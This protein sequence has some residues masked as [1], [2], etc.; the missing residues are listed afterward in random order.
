MMAVAPDARATG[1][2]DEGAPPT[3]PYY[4]DRLP[5]KPPSEVFFEAAGSPAA[6]SV[7]FKA[8]ALALAAA[9]EKAG[10]KP[11]AL[12]ADAEAL[13][14]QARLDTTR[15][16]KLCNF[17]NDVRDLFAAAPPV[18]GKP[19]ANYIRWRVEHADWFDLEWAPKKEAPN[20]GNSER[21]VKGSY[22]VLQAKAND[23]S[24]GALR[25]HWLYLMGAY[26]Y[27]EGSE[28][29]FQ[30][31]VNEFP[32][33]PRAEAARFMLARCRLVASRSHGRNG[34]EP[35]A[36]STAAGAKDRARAQELFKDYLKRYPTGRFAA[37]APGWLGA[38]AFDEG[39]YLGALGWYLQQADTPGHPEVLK[40]AGFMCERCL[41]RLSA[42]GDQ[43][44]LRQVAEHPKLAM[45]LIYLLVNT[46]ETDNNNGA[47]ETPEEVGRWRRALLPR[48]AAEVAAHESAYKSADWQPRYLAILAQAASGEG[49]QTKALALC[50]MAKDQIDRNDDLAFIRLTALQRARRLPEAVAAGRAFQEHFPHSPLARGAAL[51]MA[52]ALQ[53]NHQAGL[54]VVE[55][56][57]LQKALRAKD[58][59]SG[60]EQEDRQSDEHLYPADDDPTQY[61]YKDADLGISQSVLRHDVSGAE[62]DQ[63]AQ[64]VDVLLNFAPLPEL[65]GPLYL[66]S[67]SGLDGVEVMRLRAALAQRWLAEEE[68]FAEAKKYVTPA[69]WSVAAASLEKLAAEAAAHPA[70]AEALLRLAD[71]WAAARGKLLFSPLENDETRKALFA[72]E[73]EN[74]GLR[75]RE[76]GLALGFKA[77]SIN[78]ALECRDEWLHA[79]R[80]R[81]R[82]A[83]AAPAGSPARAR[84]LWLALKV[85]PSLALVSPYM[86]THAG[87]TDFSGLSRTLCERLRRECPNSREAR[88]FAVY[89]DLGPI[90]TETKPPAEGE[91]RAE[92]RDPLYGALSGIDLHTG[93]PEYVW[94]DENAFG[95]VTRAA[96]DGG[97]GFKGAVGR[98][99]ALPTSPLLSNPAQLAKE[100][101]DIRQALHD[102]YTER[103]DAFLLNFVDDLTDFLQEP[104]AKLTPAAVKRYIGLRAECMSVEAWGWSG[105]GLP[106][107]PG[108]TEGAI[109]DT[110]LAHIREAYKAP[111]MAAFKDY[112]DFMALAVI[113]NHPIAVPVPGETDTKDSEDGKPQPVTYRSRDYPKL[114]KLAEGFLVDYPRSHKREAA[115]LLYARALYAASRPTVR[116][117][118]AVWPASEHFASGTI[119]ATHRREPFD[120][121]K[122]G[123]ALNAYD[124]EFPKGR[125]AGEIRNL[126]ALLAWRTQDWK[127]A[128]DLTLKA[129]EDKSAPDLQAEAAVRLANVFVEGLTDE[130]E[131]ARCL[132]AIKACPGAPERL[133]AYL[134]KCG[135]PLHALKSWLLAQL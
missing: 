27:P 25:V 44:A 21:E 119:L 110:V 24:L 118:F 94:S 61:P 2:Y 115:R 8:R 9:S 13:L 132:G 64:I 104:A 80:W 67:S 33:H 43:T 11:A 56:M 74:A 12:L 65:A 16:A 46:S 51:R 79:F 5:A 131:R 128:L 108:A 45:S 117:K 127:I 134:E 78:R 53:D 60:Q 48:L 93:E 102:A 14:A 4:L 124:K 123:S 87:E 89:Y 10:A 135:Y 98:I 26:T 107:V 109:D 52:L 85:M 49:D 106:P 112:L 130:T 70:D 63:L 71:G 30:S 97:A 59:A 111:G 39:D 29:D 32:D 103:N 120:P 73:N 72:S 114:A 69:Q 100:V 47:L 83:D 126:R 62:S 86:L 15:P 90:K 1:A 22:D 34:E 31:V 17:F 92:T 40:S 50:D 20:Y 55:L 6:A 91:E 116:E 122:L 57:R 66:S 84:A 37:D 101:K 42:T 82:A 41:S 77:E 54:A 81:L 76:N 19:A 38:L 96:S 99:L 113:A 28:P 7:D 58:D 68:N 23:K 75:R 35:S 36:E 125:Y 95:N 129:L 3:L 121:R 133:Q 105:Q 18:I 88:E